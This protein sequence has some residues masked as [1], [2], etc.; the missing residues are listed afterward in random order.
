MLKRYSS[1]ALQSGFTLTELMVAVVVL[2]VLMSLAAP[3]FREFV[4]RGQIRTAT[5]SVENGLQVARA[6][7]V[8]RN[9]RIRFVI[10]S[11]TG[12]SSWTVSED[13]TGNAI[14]LSRAGGEGSASVTITSTPADATTVTFNSFGRVVANSDASTRMTQLDLTIPDAPSGS[15]RRITISP[16]GAIRLCNP[17]SNLASTDPTKC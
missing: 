6:E 15:L 9:A 13:S 7:A 3:S 16:G 2:A 12:Q 8:H 1:T 10:S 5:E 11:Q 14:Q 4:V 17:D